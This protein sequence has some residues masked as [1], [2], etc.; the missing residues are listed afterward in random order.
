[1]IK[2]VLELSIYL[3]AILFYLMLMVI[4][5]FYITK[6]KIKSSKDFMVAGRQLPN[7]VLIG[8]LVA[9]TIGSGAIVGGAN[10]IYEYGPIAGALY[11]GGT[12]IAI[13]VL[14]FIAAKVRSLNKYTLPEM[15]EIKFGPSTRFVAA[16]IILLAYIGL[17]ALQ[18]TVGAYILQLTTGMSLGL[19][20][21]ITAVIVILLA[22]T[23][24]LYSVAY[25]DYLS[26]IIIILG[27]S[28]AFFF[29]MNDVGGFSA[30]A[31]NLPDR[32]F[33]WTGGLTIIQAI[34]Y[35]IPMFLIVLGDQNTYIRFSAAKDEKN[36]KSSVI[37]FLIVEVV[38]L[39]FIIMVATSAIILFPNINPDTAILSTALYGVPIIIGV[40][41]IAAAVAITVTTAN[42]YLLS[43]AGN[44]VFDLY[45]RYRKKLSD[46][47]RLKYNRIVI[48]II[49]IF[50][51]LMGTFFSSALEIQ[52][53][54]YTMYG[55]T[56]T[57]VIIASIFWKR[58]TAA[59]ALACIITGGAST[60]IWDLILNR[61]MGWN[62]VLIALPISILA[63]ILFSL[64][65]QKKNI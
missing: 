18:F 46:K 36:A 25:T 6:R 32:H 55:A 24:G 14:Y 42:S 51:Y 20:T 19:G 28:G 17:V 8:T 45:E 34:G 16:I 23:G 39:F 7:L 47:D 48:V 12:P 63:L 5:G 56:I 29:V 50:A 4:F 65:T 26:T 9:I 15:L 33:T 35:F 3:A 57:P 2:D 11:F 41:L 60:I 31:A 10:F 44:L 54:A 52:M 1:M 43:A 62:S 27:L 58:A 37:G 30:L 22:T 64:F 13:I 38:I 53:Y 61:P 59:G 21:I 40:F 49:G